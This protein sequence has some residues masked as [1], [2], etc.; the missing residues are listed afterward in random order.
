MARM[1]HVMGAPKQAGLASQSRARNA[2]KLG[3]A[4]LGL[5]K[6]ADNRDLLMTLG[7]HEEFTLFSAVALANSQPER[8][9]VS[10][11]R[12]TSAKASALFVPAALS[13]KTCRVRLSGS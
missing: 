3:I 10:P 5:V 4:L 8:P 9:A 1:S 7:R 11:P 13:G 6:G 2:V 12:Y